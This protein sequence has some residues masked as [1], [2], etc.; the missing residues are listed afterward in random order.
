MVETTYHT[1]N[2][3]LLP[4]NR[5]VKK[6]PSQ[7]K[8]MWCVQ[9]NDRRYDFEQGTC[10]AEDLPEDIRKKCD[11]YTGSFYACIWPLK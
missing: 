10:D 2:K 5:Y 9:S 4:C 1:N 7:Q 6:I 8:Y 3:R 11:E